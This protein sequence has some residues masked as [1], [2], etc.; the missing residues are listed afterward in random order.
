MCTITTAPN[1]PSNSIQKKPDSSPSN[2]FITMNTP[3][4]KMESVHYIPWYNSKRN[5]L[6]FATR[7]DDNYCKPGIYEL[8]LESTKITFLTQ[9]IS[10]AFSGTSNHVYMSDDE[11][12][13]IIDYFQFDKNEIKI[14]KFNLSTHIMT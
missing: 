10:D 1:R 13:S 2:P 12:V 5:S 11:T 14:T 3:Q 4:F 6:I 8:D 9:Y 7:R